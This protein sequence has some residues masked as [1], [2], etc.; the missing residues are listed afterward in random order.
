MGDA[1]R[2]GGGRCGVVEDDLRP[3]E[4]FAEAGAGQG[5]WSGGAG[6]QRGAHLA[7]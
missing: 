6:E 4:E 7:L 3:P 2:R 1:A 5:D